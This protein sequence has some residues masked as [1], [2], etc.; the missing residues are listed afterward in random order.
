MCVVVNPEKVKGGIYFLLH[1]IMGLQETSVIS[2]RKVVA[3]YYQTTLGAT[4]S[5]TVAAQ[6]KGRSFVAVLPAP[7]S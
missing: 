4:R 3:Q 7:H 5:R 1:K 6:N 2:E